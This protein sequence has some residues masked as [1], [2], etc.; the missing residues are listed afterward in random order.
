MQEFKEG[1][2][3]GGHE[4]RS[5]TPVRI[6][7]DDSIEPVPDLAAFEGEW[8]STVC[9]GT[10]SIACQVSGFEWRQQEVHSGRGTDGGATSVVAPTAAETPPD[11][12]TTDPIVKEEAPGHE[13]GEC[14]APPEVDADMP[15][16]RRPR[17][18]R[19]LTTHR[20]DSSS[21][22]VHTSGIT[23]T[24]RKHQLS[25]GPKGGRPSN[26][27]NPMRLTARHFMSVIPPTA[28]KSNPTRV[29][30]VCAQSKTRQTK[31]KESRY[32]CSACEMPLCVVP[33]FEQYH[34]K[35]V[36]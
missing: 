11:G 4:K 15:A 34:T 28:A 23:K 22:R 27:D 7:T 12:A 36:F 29:C 20:F 18:P 8:E 10:R 19:R 32:M 3:G 35:K 30:H 33:C 21:S 5:L 24:S 13:D 31:R 16:V 9:E 25:A 26:G 6:T 14:N 17:R 2:T 1:H